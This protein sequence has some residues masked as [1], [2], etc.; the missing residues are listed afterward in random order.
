MNFVLWSFSRES[1]PVVSLATT[2]HCFDYKLIFRIIF[3]SSLY[4]YSKAAHNF[5]LAFQ[6]FWS[7]FFQ[8]HHHHYGNAEKEWDRKVVASSFLLL[9]VRRMKAMS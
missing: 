5:R 3:F 8:S 6:S 7:L 4:L 1:S 9:D 2:S